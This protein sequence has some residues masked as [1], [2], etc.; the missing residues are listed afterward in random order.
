[1]RAHFELFMSVSSGSVKAGPGAQ[2]EKGQPLRLRVYIRESM[3]W[4][5]DDAGTGRCEVTPTDERETQPFAAYERQLR[6][7]D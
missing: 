3:E 4:K 2:P 7:F 1:M 5:K 6:K